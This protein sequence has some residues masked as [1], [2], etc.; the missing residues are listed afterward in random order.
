MNRRQVV[1]DAIMELDLPL[2][3][4]EGY[5][6]NL[7]EVFD[8]NEHGTTP[9]GFLMSGFDWAPYDDEGGE[10]DDEIFEYWNKL[11][12]LLGGDLT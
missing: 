2:E 11:H 12:E 10:Y 5:V 3:V 7:P 4:K 9:S 6:S 1:I 8:E